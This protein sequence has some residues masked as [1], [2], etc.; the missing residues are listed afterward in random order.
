MAATLKSLMYHNIKVIMTNP[1]PLNPLNE[2]VL[3]LQHK[4]GF[5]P[6]F[7]SW[8]HNKSF[9]N[10]HIQGVIKGGQNILQLDQEVRRAFNR[11]GRMN[12]CT[13]NST[14]NNGCESCLLLYA[15]NQPWT[16]SSESKPQNYSNENQSSKNKNSMK[17]RKKVCQKNYQ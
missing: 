1:K 8:K 10:I 6:I 11:D 13:S 4:K 5:H 3:T 17:K 16:I 14:C 7:R 9:Q 15:I 12:A 2:F